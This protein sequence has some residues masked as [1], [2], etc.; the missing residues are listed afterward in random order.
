MTTAVSRPRSVT[1]RITTPGAP[2]TVDASAPTLA[3]GMY[4]ATVY[5][6]THRDN[7]DG[8]QPHHPLAAATRPD[9]SPLHLVF[10][11]GKRITDH[12][13]AASAAVTVGNRQA[14]DDHGQTWPADIRPSPS[15]TSSRSPT[16]TTGSSTS[17]STRS[18]SP[19]SPS[20]PP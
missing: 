7:Y 6:N 18:A 20:P 12:Q 11:A 1:A 16:S 5:M 15:A 14:R 4:T 17:A 9:G 13:T 2:A 10:H 8:Y 19:T 3:P